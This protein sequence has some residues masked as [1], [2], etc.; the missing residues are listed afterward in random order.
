M[1]VSALKKLLYTHSNFRKKKSV[2]EQ[3]APN[4]DRFF[5]GRQIAHMTYEYF[6]ATGAYEA[7]QGLADLLTLSLQNDDVQDFDVR[8]NHAPLTVIEM[9]SDAIL[10]GL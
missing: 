7:A 3:G 5:R 8:W 6:R 10:E 1:I 9:R 4:S 2:E